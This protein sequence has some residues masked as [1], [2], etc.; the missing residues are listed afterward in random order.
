MESGEEVTISHKLLWLMIYSIHLQFSF[1]QSSE[2]GMERKLEERREEV[3]IQEFDQ[4]PVSVNRC[5]QT[6]SH[7]E[8]R[9]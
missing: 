3:K 7:A 6:T 5:Q 4:S 1:T 9:L 8:R 2:R